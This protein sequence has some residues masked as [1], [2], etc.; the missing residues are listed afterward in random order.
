[1]IAAKTPDEY[2]LSEARATYGKEV[3]PGS[4]KAGVFWHTQGSGKS[5]SMCCYAGKL[6]Q[7]PAMNN[8]TLVVVTDR[9]DLDGQLFQTFS[10]AQ[11][12]FRQTPVQ[13]N[14]RSELRQ[15]L[16]ERESGGIIFTTVQKFSPFEKEDG[17]PILNDRHNIVVISDE[18]HRSQYGQK[19][20]FIDVKDENGNVTGSKLV[21]GYS[22][23]M[24]M[25]WTMVQLC[26][27][28]TNHA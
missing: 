18:A 24:R 6:L 13:A 16:S 7:Q 2:Q 26:L 28:I 17:H 20:R 25:L 3:V 9:S 19:G 5:I 23:Y 11:E 21:F 14:S 22:K 27:F 4:K 8:P 15:L 1:V 12:L 10:N